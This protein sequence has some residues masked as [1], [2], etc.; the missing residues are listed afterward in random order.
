M[1]LHA[2]KDRR[3]LNQID[4]FVNMVGK[5]VTQGSDRGVATLLVSPGVIFLLNN[6]NKYI[7]HDKEGDLELLGLTVLSMT[8][9]KPT[10]TRTI[11]QSLAGDRTKSS[12]LSP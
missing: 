9:A 12:G 11:T 8:S 6:I 10:G 1:L 4:V 7:N 5:A 3:W 2:R